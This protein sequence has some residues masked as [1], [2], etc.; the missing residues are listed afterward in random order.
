MEN[1]E[2]QGQAT[3]SLTRWK[4]DPAHSEIGFAA[5]H[6]MI[7]TVRGRFSEVSGFIAFDEG[8]LTSASIDVEIGVASVDTRQE[9]RDN[10]LRSADFFDAE[11]HPSM[12][13][14]STKIEPTK[15]DQYKITGDLTIRGTSHEVTLD[16]S[17]EGMHA[18]PWG[19]TRAGFS[20][21]GKINRHDFGLNW[22]AT[23][24]AGGVVVGPEIKIQLDVE[25]VKQAE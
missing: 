6:M 14:V 8:D 23:I 19:G 18:D 22:N 20:A 17:F 2:T 3:K 15:G 13:F 11:N 5:K 24:E 7:S 10:H 25:A 9:G 16:A 21:T 4:I 12:K 1:Q